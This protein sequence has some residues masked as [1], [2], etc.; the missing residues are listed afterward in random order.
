MERILYSKYCLFTRY[1]VQQVTDGPHAGNQMVVWSGLMSDDE[2]I[3]GKRFFSTW[4]V[5][6]DRC[7]SFPSPQ[8]KRGRFSDDILMFHIYFYILLHLFEEVC[9]RATSPSTKEIPF[10]PVLEEKGEAAL[11]FTYFELKSILPI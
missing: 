7:D 4:I 2:F 11:I 3:T 5:E 8:R 10:V 9:P 1:F 6:T